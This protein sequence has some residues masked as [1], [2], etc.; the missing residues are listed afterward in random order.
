M[1]ENFV[2]GGRL[3]QITEISEKQA[4][5]IRFLL[6]KPTTECFHELF[7]VLDSIFERWNQFVLV[8][9]MTNVSHFK[10]I[11]HGK[12][13]ISYLKSRETEI[14]S[15]LKFSVLLIKSPTAQSLLNFVF[16]IR[17]PKRPNKILLWDQNDQYLR[18]L[19]QLLDNA[20]V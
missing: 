8:F 3:V 15:R 20:E 6:D 16:R 13:V 5:F 11:V 14:E 18:K 10:P 7:E 1:E 9:D 17:P 4:I 12:K 2:F 19:E